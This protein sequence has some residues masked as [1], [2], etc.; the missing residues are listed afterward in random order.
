MLVARRDTSLPS[1]GRRQEVPSQEHMV[2]IWCKKAK[3]NR[4]LIQK[5]STYTISTRPSSPIHIPLQVEA[6]HSLWSWTQGLQS[7][8]SQKILG[9]PCSPQTTGIR[10]CAKNIY[11]WIDA[12]YW[13]TPCSYRSQMQPL[14]LVV[15]A[16]HGPS[17][18]GRNWLK[19]LGLVVVPEWRVTQFKPTQAHSNADG[20]S[21]L[22]ADRSNSWTKSGFSKCV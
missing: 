21:R 14:V 2:R 9:S 6:N 20:L 8:S 12:G 10:H 5:N 13:T 22:H 11:G 19:Y 15:V 7:P 18:V 17:L 3:G 4:T 1:A 16:G